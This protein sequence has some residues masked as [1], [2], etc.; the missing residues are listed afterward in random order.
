MAFGF[1]AAPGTPAGPC[2]GTCAHL[3][4]AATRAAAASLC[5]YCQRPIGYDVRYYLDPED[6]QRRVHAD[7]HEDAV[8]S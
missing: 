2:A 1:M 4:C 5:R 6:R 8:W 7:C 3:D